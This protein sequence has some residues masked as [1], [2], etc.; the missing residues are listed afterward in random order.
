MDQNGLG[1]FELYGLGVVAVTHFLYSA[2]ADSS[3]GRCL[4]GR[5][6]RFRLGGS[7]P[8]PE[9]GGGRLYVEAVRC[10][11]GPHSAH[12]GHPGC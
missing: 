1:H 12:G 5:R 4:P 3:R 7:T 2:Y 6:F 10:A 9:A 8:C 11:S